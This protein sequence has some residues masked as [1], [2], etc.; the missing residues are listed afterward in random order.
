MSQIR[1]KE[2]CSEKGISI[3]KLAE[4]VGM[5]RVS[6]SNM[7]AGRQSPPVD[8]LDKIADALGVETWVLLK[9]PQE[10]GVSTSSEGEYM[11]CPK[12]GAK[13]QIVEYIEPSPELGE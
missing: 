4:L 8:T 2:L 9:D 1:I 3:V 5:S 7:V 13:L 10:L 12:C 6:I 11:K